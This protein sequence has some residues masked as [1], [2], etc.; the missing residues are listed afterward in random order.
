MP[1]HVL[2]G[3]LLVAT[4]AGCQTIDT[5]TEKVKTAAERLNAR[6]ET[7]FGTADLHQGMTE[8]DIDVAAGAFQKAMEKADDGERVPWANPQS[9]NGGGFQP[10]RTYMTD[11]GTFCRDFEETLRVDSRE[12]SY[13]N[14][15]CRRETGGWVWVRN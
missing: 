13:R 3:L 2:I 15:A 10:V 6:L 4:L 5:A 9:G 7:A 1:R 12:D 14:V 8:R 11:A